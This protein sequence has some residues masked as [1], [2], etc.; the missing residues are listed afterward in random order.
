[1]LVRT[2]E[3]KFRARHIYPTSNF[4]TRLSTSAFILYDFP[5]QNTESD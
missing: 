5:L 3:R 4:A 2:K 1:M